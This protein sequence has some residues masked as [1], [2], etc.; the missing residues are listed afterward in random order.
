MKKLRCTED[1][2]KFPLINKKEPELFRDQFP[3]SQVP[4]ILFEE[5]FLLPE[6]PEEIWIT[7]TTFRDGQQARPPYTPKQI[8][9]LFTLLH[10]LG[11][12]NGVIR[13]SEFFLYSKR[14]REALE[15]CRSKNHEFPEITGWIRA[16]AEDLKLVQA[17]E[18]KETGILTSVSD[19][20]IYL[21]LKK[22]R[23]KALEDYLAIVKEALN[24]GIRPRC[25]FEDITRADIY[26]FCLPFA[27]ELLKLMNESGI[28]IKIRLCDTMGYGIS[29]PG[30]VLPRSVPKL[31]NALHKELRYPSELL[32]WHGHNDFH[33]VH[34]NGSTAWLYG[35]S[36]L[37]TSLLGYG[38]RTGN[39]PLEGAVMEYIGLTGSENGMDTRVITEIAEY[40][41]NEIKADIP[42]NF[43]FIGADFNTTR[44]GIH[45]DG[46][47]KNQEIY[48][49]F[50]TDRILNRPLKVTVTD[51]SGAAGIARW[52]NENIDLVK[53]GEIPAVSK[54]D[55]GIQPINQWVQK[56]YADG[57]TTGISPEEL[58]AQSKHYLPHLFVSDF[59]LIQE[60]V[61]K[62]AMSLS[63][64][65]TASKDI[66]SL[67]E[68]IIEPYLTG[69]VKREPSIQL[70]AITNLNGYRISQVYTQRG[71]KG[72][73]RSLLNKDFNTKE[74]F[75]NVKKSGEA[76]C[77]N[78][79]RSRF[80]DEMIIT[81]AL[82]LRG[83]NDEI[84][85]I[86]DID[87]KFNELVKMQSNIPDEI[88]SL[89]E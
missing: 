53:S 26:G 84:K 86:I 52:L 15:I 25:H 63:S 28:P 4:R 68:E 48:N 12:P 17:L 2:Y 24:A 88:L 16:V 5:F 50:D 21:K 83:E 56:Q 19:Y 6:P 85:A 65:I 67:K 87:F 81:T 23:V 58:I 31:V 79:F 30:A 61:I 42:T 73:F 64:I 62:K 46:I 36:A 10:R 69:I 57:R 20:H 80:T 33:K 70:L 78:L 22:N 74:W 11:G 7:D 39:P 49:I 71:E 1:L 54:R 3:F 41:T 29:Y 8:G 55:P 66:Q 51:K 47:L 77:S 14:D 59:E 44:A 75:L 72:R 34:I 37:N 76:Y 13:Q 43:P 40:F 38:E 32:E 60:K 9:D 89:G 82:P 35:I 18:L 27:A 45:A